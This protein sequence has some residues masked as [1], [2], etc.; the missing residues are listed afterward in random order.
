MRFAQRVGEVPEYLFSQITRKIAEKEAQGLE[1]ISFGIGD[2]DQ[3][4]PEHVVS[5]LRRASS[6]P[7]NHRYPESN[8]LP[9]FRQA[10]AHWYRRRVGVALD[11]ESEVVSLIGAKEGIGHASLCFIDPGDTAL[12][13]NPG[14]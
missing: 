7:S 5:A 11:P 3:P 1:V 4:T 2:P 13:P 9:E 10:V 12:V 14:S 8:G 6:E